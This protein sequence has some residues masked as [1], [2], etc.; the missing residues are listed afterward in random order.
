MLRS[1]GRGSERLLLQ[2]TNPATAAASARSHIFH[3]SRTIPEDNRRAANAS[4][5]LGASSFR[6]YDLLLL[7]ATFSRSNQ[8]TTRQTMH[9]ECARGPENRM[10]FKERGGPAQT[11]CRV[12][13]WLVGW[14]VYT[15]DTREPPMHHCECSLAFF[16]FLS[17]PQERGL[18]FLSLLHPRTK[19]YGTDDD[20]IIPQQTFCC[21]PCC[22]PF[23]R[24]LK[25]K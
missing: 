1:I 18:I 6:L 12:V 16:F 17:D 2:K 9:S 15:Q 23:N 20:V 10:C 5:P 21:P 8:N 4:A 22:F 13:G 11:H 3:P 19:N 25:G 24:Q 14:L 7:L